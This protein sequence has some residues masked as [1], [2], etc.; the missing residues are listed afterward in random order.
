MLDKRRQAGTRMVL[1]GPDQL[2]LALRLFRDD[3]LMAKR[4]KTSSSGGT[5]IDLTLRQLS[6]ANLLI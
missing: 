1:D 5:A 4:E 2:E 6:G 3:S